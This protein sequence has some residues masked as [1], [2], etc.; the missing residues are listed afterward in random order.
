MSFSIVH[1]SDP[2]FGGVA[3][4]ELIEGVEALVPDLEPRVIVVAGDLSQRARHGEFQAA[5]HFVRELER[6][7]PVYVLPGNHDVQWWRRPLLPFGAEAKYAKYLSYFGPALG[8]P[9]L[10][11][12][13][14]VAIPGPMERVA[15]S[16]FGQRIWG[17]GLADC[18]FRPIAP[19]R[20]RYIQE[21][22]YPGQI[23]TGNIELLGDVG[24]GLGPDQPVEFFSG[25]R[26]FASPFLT[27]PQGAA[28]Y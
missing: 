23:V 15:G 3:D 1:L 24:H 22:A 9:W 20:P 26:H 17:R 11:R 10:W 19:L 18:Q 2:H 28:R 5:R 4:L 14:M 12:R 27:A 16:C 7:A 25:N 13:L 6:T 8:R 21:R